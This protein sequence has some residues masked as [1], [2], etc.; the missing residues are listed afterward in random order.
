MQCSPALYHHT[1]PHH[2]ALHRTT[3]HRTALHCTAP[4]HTT[5][6]QHILFGT[7]LHSTTSNNHLFPQSLDS[8]RKQKKSSVTAVQ[9]NGEELIEECRSH[10]NI[11]V[12]LEQALS[13]FS[14]RW[15]T[16]GKLIEDRKHKAHLARQRR[17][18]Q[19]LMGKVEVPLKEAE[20]LIARFGADVPGSEYELK[21]QFDQCNVSQVKS[22]IIFYFISISTMLGK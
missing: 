13:S 9:K 3:Q 4:Y 12:T 14:D 8:G 16:V 10:G 17:E 1:A 5:T 22:I 11:P 20:R 21:S 7:L 6:A 18:V 2:T 15:D 19:D